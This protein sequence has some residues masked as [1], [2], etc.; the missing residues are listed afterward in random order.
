M[1][2]SL[3]PKAMFL[4]PFPA[5]FPDHFWNLSAFSINISTQTRIVVKII[6]FKQAF[7]IHISHCSEINILRMK[8]TT[9]LDLSKLRDLGIFL[10]DMFQIC[11]THKQILQCCPLTEP[12]STFS[13]G[14]SSKQLIPTIVFKNAVM[15]YIQLISLQNVL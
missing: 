11:M 10:N 13:E 15:I 12:N 1:R 7:V 6:T 14:L 9:G 2:T 3:N 4:S 5:P 8:S